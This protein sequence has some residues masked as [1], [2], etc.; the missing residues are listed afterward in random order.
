MSNKRNK[1]KFTYHF[2][3]RMLQKGKK[4]AENNN[5]RTVAGTVYL[6]K[7]AGPGLHEMERMVEGP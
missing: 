2:L 1:L 5:T 3:R 4:T 6:C 7:L